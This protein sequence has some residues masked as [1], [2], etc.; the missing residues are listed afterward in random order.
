MTIKKLQEVVRILKDW[1]MSIYIYERGWKQIPVFVVSKLDFVFLDS[2][3]HF[4]VREQFIILT[5]D[6]IYEGSDVFCLK[7][8]HI[9]NHAQLF[10]GKDILWKQTYILSDLRSSLE[11]DIRNKLVQL[12]EEYLSQE[13]GK[14]FLHNLL[15]G[16]QIIWEGS[17]LLKNPDLVI[18]ENMK[19]L[20]SLFDVAWS[21]NSQKFYYLIDDQM[22]E[23]Q[24][25]VFIQDV[26]TYL[27]EICT[28]INNFTL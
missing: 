19:E 6:D 4:F 2:I 17:L 14:Y 26:H 9:K 20:L 25:P 24:V 28:K 1:L 10:Y 12:R 27:L 13:K 21:C 8:L 3:R 15:V 23:R 11:L 7:L 22:E 18:P 16:M 5:E